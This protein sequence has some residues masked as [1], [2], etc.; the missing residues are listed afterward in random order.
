M[1]GPGW[2]IQL[3]KPQRR[4]YVLRPQSVLARTEMEAGSPRQRRRFNTAPTRIQVVW[5]FTAA[6]LQSFEAW[7]HDSIQSGAAW[8]SVE[9]KFATGL[10]TVSA[11]FVKRGQGEYDA[12]PVGATRWEVIAELETRNPPRLYRVSNELPTARDVAA[13]V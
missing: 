2:P 4:S 1:S 10:D 8:F 9:L 6:Q 7:F 3:P 12:K 13:G 5:W 11:R